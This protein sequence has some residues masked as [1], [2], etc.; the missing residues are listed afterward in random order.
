M[1]KYHFQSSSLL[2]NER[3]RGSGQIYTAR[4]THSFTHLGAVATVVISPEKLPSSRFTLVGLRFLSFSP[5]LFH[6]IFTFQI[7]FLTGNEF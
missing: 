5:V 6:D 2:A 3:V 7:L 4:L 1:E